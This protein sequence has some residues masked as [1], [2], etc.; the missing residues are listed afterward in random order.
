MFILILILML[1]FAVIFVYKK[2]KKIDKSKY[3]ILDNTTLFDNNYTKLINRALL[4]ATTTNMTIVWK[5]KIMNI[6]ENYLW[7]DNF[8]NPKTIIKN[9]T[10]PDILYEPRDNILVIRTQYY[11]TEKIKTHEI[12]IP[13]IPIQ[14]WTSYAIV[15]NGRDLCVYINNNLYHC[16]TLPNVFLSPIGDMKV[17]E[18][19]NN[20]LGYIDDMAYYN[21]CLSMNEISRL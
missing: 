18:Q 17:G 21:R 8:R 10:A 15:I 2:Y 19:L 11:D 7:A 4:P 6:S 5:M 20:F 12:K 16:Y 13:N 3:V 14:I 9:N 1:I